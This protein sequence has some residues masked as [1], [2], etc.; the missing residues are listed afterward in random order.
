MQSPTLYERLILQHAGPTQ[1][2]FR[3][4]IQP[5][6]VIKRWQSVFPRRDNYRVG[7][8]RYQTRW[9]LFSI[10]MVMFCRLKVSDKRRILFSFL[11]FL[12]WHQAAEIF[13]CWKFGT[14]TSSMQSFRMKDL[15]HLQE[16]S[17]IASLP[18]AVQ[19]DNIWRGNALWLVLRRGHAVIYRLDGPAPSFLLSKKCCF[20]VLRTHKNRR[21][22]IWPCWGQVWG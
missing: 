13:T 11:S 20:W 16:L 18:H 19:G 9:C 3:V 6:F 22:G 5:W 21:W 7:W 1:C 2:T 14:Q 8:K 12:S 4:K 10:F 15:S 17:A